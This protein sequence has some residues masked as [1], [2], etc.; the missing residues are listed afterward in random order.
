MLDPQERPV[1]HVFYTAYT[2]PSRT[3]VTRPVTFA[4][5][6]G[7]G[8]SAIF[9]HFGGLGPK[10]VQ[11]G[12]EGDYPSTSG[13]ATDNPD[14]WLPFTDLVFVDPVGTGFSRS[15]VSD[16]EARRLFYGT[17]SDAAYISRFIYD[18]LVA[19]GRIA[20]PL[21]L[22]GESYGG[23]RVPKIAVQLQ[24]R[25]GARVRG[26]ILV[27]PYLDRAY[28]SYSDS[29]PLL[30]VKLLP[31]YAA[32]QITRQRGSVTPGDLAPVEEYARGEYLVDLLRGTRD[33][34]ALERIA[35]RVSQYTGLERALVRRLNG[36]VDPETF[37]REFRRDEGTVIS[38]YD[39]DVWAFD[40][41][42][43][44]AARRRQGD[45][46]LDR[47]YSP[48]IPALVDLVSRVI[49]WTPTSP[50]VALNYDVNRAWDW[51]TGG[52]VVGTSVESISDIRVAMSIDPSLNVLIANG[53]TDMTTTYFESRLAADQIPV[54][55]RAE[56]L[57]LATYPGGHMFYSRPDSRA[58]F[59]SDVRA[60]YDN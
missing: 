33:A 11:F 50:Y 2:V 3:S 47:M 26:L 8:A 54:M 9:L 40:P 4:F 16:E 29:S 44:S 32:A 5:N 39:A 27:S 22:V 28:F 45:P 20:S 49:G 42:P 36:R 24:T 41:F 19:N 10:L 43:S 58:Q 17:E 55:G 23:F 56:Q 30:W 35:E 38:R 48:T 57:R 59:T 37:V 18:W 6:G 15:N 34:A 52:A 60:V 31:A 13:G 21:Y 53:L 14:T 7:P 1:G 46:I 12:N 25:L 51:G